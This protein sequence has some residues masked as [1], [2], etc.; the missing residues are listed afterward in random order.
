MK[1]NSMFLNV[2][3][4]QY[5]PPFICRSNGISKNTRISLRGPS[6]D[7][8]ELHVK[9]HSM[10]RLCIHNGWREFCAINN[11][12]LGDLCFFRIIKNIKND[13][14]AMSESI[15]MDVKVSKTQ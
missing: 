2:L 13:A 12:K 10:G 6:R 3:W 8:Y 11:I 9:E 1:T 4:E 7:W 14:Q 5:I 15:V